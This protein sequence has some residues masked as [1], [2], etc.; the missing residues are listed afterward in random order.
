MKQ[1]LY[2]DVERRG[3]ILSGFPDLLLDMVFAWDRSNSTVSKRRKEIC[4]KYSV[5]NNMIVNLSGICVSDELEKER[6]ARHVDGLL[7]PIDAESVGNEWICSDPR[8][9]SP[10]SE[11]PKDFDKLD[12]S[13]AKWKFC[14][15]KV[16]WLKGLAIGHKWTVVLDIL[17]EASPKDYRAFIVR[18]LNR[19]FPG[20]PAGYYYT[21][22]GVIDSL[23][24]LTTVIKAKVP[25]TLSGLGGY[26]VDLHQLGGYSTCYNNSLTLMDEWG[27][28]FREAARRLNDLQRRREMEEVHQEIRRVVREWGVSSVKI[29]QPYTGEGYI[30]DRGNW[31]VSGASTLP[32]VEADVTID[33]NG[34]KRTVRKGFSGKEMS[35]SAYSADSLWDYCISEGG[36]GEC[37]Y[38]FQKG[39]EPAKARIVVN[40]DIRSYL[41]VSFLDHFLA[42]GPEWTGIEK[43]NE[44][45]AQLYER[46]QS[47][48]EGGC[49]ISLDYSGWDH[50]VTV[51]LVISV[52]W[53]VR[54]LI[55]SKLRARWGNIPWVEKVIQD[56]IDAAECEVV[57]LRTIKFDLGEAGVLEGL[58]GFLSS[59]HKWTA[60]ANT[61]INR[62]LFNVV[63]RRIKYGKVRFSAHQGDDVAVVLDSM[64]E[65]EMMEYTRRFS[66]VVN[67]WGFEINPSK[68]S[69]CQSGV[70]FLRVWVTRDG[71]FAYPGRMLR[72]MLW[73]KPQGDEG[74]YNS[75]IQKVQETVNS[76]LSAERRG[77]LNIG[78]IAR[79]IIQGYLPKR[80]SKKDRGRLMKWLGTSVTL[81]GLYCPGFRK[82][83]GLNR[84]FLWAPKLERVGHITARRWTIK[85][86]GKGLR[87][88]YL[89]VLQ[90][91]TDEFA[92]VRTRME[93]LVRDQ[94]PISGITNRIRW[95][96]RGSVKQ[97]LEIQSKVRLAK[98]NGSIPPAPPPPLAT[99]GDG[100]GWWAC[101]VKGEACL[102]GGN[103][104]FNILSWRMLVSERFKI[105]LQRYS[106]RITRR[107]IMW[108]ENARQP[109]PAD[110]SFDELSLWKGRARLSKEWDYYY[111]YG[112]LFA[113]GG[114][115]Q[116]IGNGISS[117]VV[118][119]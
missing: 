94:V 67:R 53:G 76:A 95:I 35:T 114:E 71:C 118:P 60:T 86:D 17:V 63:N 20:L 82:G 111:T 65:F 13:L 115:F 22:Q 50:S 37:A 113:E 99:E 77:L 83:L 84:P 33:V 51:D 102:S 26:L 49:G 25:D 23:K 36:L 57:S 93:Q 44:G 97:L 62:A 41:R 5:L 30:H 79:E 81:G 54:D 74:I 90:P 42:T 87:N 52:I 46:M 47:E 18:C 69:M 80:L 12:H 112:I 117:H 55:V 24:Q 3:L 48:L 103:R 85:P 10:I 72:T 109:P 107:I 59:G 40:H 75:W 7:V 27:A 21:E 78:P 101:R 68:T 100:P 106:R 92:V 4:N 64:S 11:G 14:R 19:L 70:E 88:S 9:V 108:G 43:G 89:T 16:K 58:G 1:F 61:I 116:L 34:E 6:V 66:E 91:Q 31:A 38:P 45:M 110:V 2:I 119:M 39:D 56:V 96:Y 105:F 28:A 98:Q 15:R 32:G 29:E 73:S 104:K 8:K